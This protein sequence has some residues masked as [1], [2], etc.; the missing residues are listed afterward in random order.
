[1]MGFNPAA[2]E[3]YLPPVKPG[4]SSVTSV[5]ALLVEAVLFL[6]TSTAI[7]RCLFFE[8]PW[9]TDSIIWVTL[10]S[11]K[12]GQYAMTSEGSSVAFTKQ[13]G[14]TL[15]LKGSQSHELQGQSGC[16]LLQHK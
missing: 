10:T 6:G 16:G 1:M 11:L 4:P 5:G 8:R 15:F 3:E 7:L 9:V 14:H 12:T 13:A 2:V